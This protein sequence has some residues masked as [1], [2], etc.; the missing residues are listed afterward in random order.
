MVCNNSPVFDI[1]F[2]IFPLAWRYRQFLIIQLPFQ[3]SIRLSVRRVVRYSSNIRA[4]P[5]PVVE[6]WSL[7]KHNSVFAVTIK[8]GFISAPLLCSATVV[9]SSERWRHSWFTTIRPVRQ[10][11]NY[12]E[13]R[14]F[15]DLKCIFHIASNSCCNRQLVVYFMLADNVDW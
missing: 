15:G 1:I 11:I 10:A 9:Q 13:H 5:D 6:G 7:K 2:H 12:L 3:T 8:N 14:T 4:Q